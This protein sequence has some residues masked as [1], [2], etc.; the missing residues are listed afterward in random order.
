MKVVELDLVVEEMNWW[1]LKMMIGKRVTVKMVMGI[2][3]WCGI[4]RVGD[5]NWRREMEMG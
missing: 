3:E 4:W 2:E 1:R 5:A